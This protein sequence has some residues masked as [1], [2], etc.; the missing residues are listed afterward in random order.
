MKIE[1]GEE[2]RYRE[3]FNL[4]T[5]ENCERALHLEAGNDIL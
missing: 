4:K 5:I 2:I 1:A 3:M